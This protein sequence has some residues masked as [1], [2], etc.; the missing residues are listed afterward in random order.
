MCTPFKEN[1][2]CAS[3]PHEV[4]QG[5][6]REYT[7]PEREAMSPLKL[8]P[9]RGNLK[10]PG[11]ICFPKARDPPGGNSKNSCFAGRKKRGGGGSLWGGGS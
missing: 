4:A 9:P 10:Y 5:T 3:E 6:L 2:L 11:R 7:T 8:H 1:A